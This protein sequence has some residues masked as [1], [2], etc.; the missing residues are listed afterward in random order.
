MTATEFETFQRETYNRKIRE[1]HSNLCDLVESG[2]MTAA[3]ANE[4]L[5]AKQEQW[6]GE[7]I[8]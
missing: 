5:V 2:D 1:L 7:G 6:R 4:W 8:N 3:E